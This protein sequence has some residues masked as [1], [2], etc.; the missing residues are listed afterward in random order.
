MVVALLPGWH[1]LVVTHGG[2]PTLG[3]YVV[4]VSVTCG[5][6]RRCRQNSTVS[7]SQPCQYFTPRR[8]QGIWNVVGITSASNWD[9]TVAGVTSSLPGVRRADAVVAN[10]HLG[11]IPGGSATSTG[12]AARPAHRPSTP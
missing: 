8:R 3:P 1:A 2:F 11:A 10:G 5:T 6:P 7:V 12:R 9:L 4:D